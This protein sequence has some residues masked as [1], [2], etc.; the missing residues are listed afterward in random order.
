MVRIRVGGD[1]K[2]TGGGERGAEDGATKLD[3]SGVKE[4]RGGERGC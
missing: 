3:R 2:N 1:G 4:L